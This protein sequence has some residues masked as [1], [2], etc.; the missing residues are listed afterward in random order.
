M[1][2]PKANTAAVVAAVILVSD[3]AHLRLQ[4]GEV[5]PGKVHPAYASSDGMLA[6]QGVPPVGQLSR[7]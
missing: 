1:Q 3:R 4:N 5:G 7:R 2:I 6:P